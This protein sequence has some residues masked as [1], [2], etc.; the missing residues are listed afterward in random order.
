MHS[1]FLQRCGWQHWNQKLTFCLAVYVCGVVT[2]LTVGREISLLGSP[3][4]LKSVWHFQRQ[5]PHNSHRCTPALTHICLTHAHTGGCAALEVTTGDV[6]SSHTPPTEHTQLSFYKTSLFLFMLPNNQNKRVCIFGMLSKCRVPNSEF[7]LNPECSLR[8]PSW[9]RNQPIVR[10][11][12]GGGIHKTVK[13]QVGCVKVCQ[14]W[15]YCI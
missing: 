15:I 3:L 8:I 11:R 1:S 4:S 12:V 14:L 7:V 6:T 2:S 9:D 13:E 10:S 5:E